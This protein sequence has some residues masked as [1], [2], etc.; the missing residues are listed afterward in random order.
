MAN[1]INVMTL[2]QIE[3]FKPATTAR[4]LKNYL[5]SGEGEVNNVD[6]FLAL[7]RLVQL[8][9]TF[10]PLL[11]KQIDPADY[12]EE[13]IRIYRPRSWSPYMMA[14]F[15][16]LRKIFAPREWVLFWRHY[17]QLTREEIDEFAPVQKEVYQ[18]L[19]ALGDEMLALHGQWSSKVEGAGYEECQ[20]RE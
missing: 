13:L 5:Y 20:A 14:S 10:F 7:L 15:L 9:Y 19:C 16:K 2:T 12:R 4:R 6:N 3:I 11:N 1:S 17:N 18:K 8:I